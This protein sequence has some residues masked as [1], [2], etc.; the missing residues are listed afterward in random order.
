MPSISRG[1]D[2]STQGSHHLSYELTFSHMVILLWL[3]AKA[4]IN[5]L[6]QRFPRILPRDPSSRRPALGWNLLTLLDAPSPILALSTE[7]Y[8]S[9][10]AG[11]AIESEEAMA[12]GV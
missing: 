5:Y 9:Q 3:A 4:A 7:L 1:F 12:A 2:S 11:T 6:V 8:G 10:P